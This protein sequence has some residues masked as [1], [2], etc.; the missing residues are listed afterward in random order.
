[1]QETDNRQPSEVPGAPTSQDV[2]DSDTTAN[3]ASN[4]E[5]QNQQQNEQQSS[6]RSEADG[7]EGHAGLSRATSQKQSGTTENKVCLNFWDVLMSNLG[8]YASVI[9]HIFCQFFHSDCALSTR[10]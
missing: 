7:N 10:K 9:Y 6:G 1:M 2:M 4:T 5:Q 3:N 8:T